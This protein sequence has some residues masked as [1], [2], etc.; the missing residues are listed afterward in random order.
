MPTKTENP[1]NVT[2]ALDRV[3]ATE[4]SALEPEVVKM[5]V[6]SLN[7]VSPCIS[8]IDKGR[9]IIMPDFDEPLP[10]FDDE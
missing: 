9:M 6:L 2:E 7:N 5:Q 8:G 1:E 3:Y 4:S 10:E